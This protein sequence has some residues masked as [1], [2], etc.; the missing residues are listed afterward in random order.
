MQPTPYPS[1]PSSV[2]FS[3]WENPSTTELVSL[4]GERVH[5]LKE[6]GWQANYGMT[7]STEAANKKRA[8]A[9][10]AADQW[11]FAQLGRRCA[12][13]QMFLSM[14]AYFD[15]AKAELGWKENYGKLTST[16]EANKKRHEAESKALRF[17]ADKFQMDVKEIQ[18]LLMRP[19]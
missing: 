13:G 3:G 5:K 14:R 12:Q 7:T 9:E 4:A 1:A 10:A 17:T 2:Q 19:T 6:F 16:D 8:E 18:G 15:N 11:F